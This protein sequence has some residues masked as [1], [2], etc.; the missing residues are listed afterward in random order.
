MNIKKYLLKPVFW[1]AIM[2]CI[3]QIQGAGDSDIKE[4][5]VSIKLKNAQLSD[6]FSVLDSKTQFSFSYGEYVLNKKERYDAIYEN[7]PLYEILKV[8]PE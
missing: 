4:A 8:C 1:L 2:G 3:G 5:K 6:I 7:S